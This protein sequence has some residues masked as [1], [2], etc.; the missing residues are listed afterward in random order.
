MFTIFMHGY[1]LHLVWSIPTLITIKQPPFR[2]LN[3][4]IYGNVKCRYTWNCT[5]LAIALPNMYLFFFKK[6]FV[7]FIFV[8]FRLD[9]FLTITIW[10]SHFFIMFSSYMLL[11]VFNTS[12]MESTFITLCTIFYDPFFL[13]KYLLSLCFQ[14]TKF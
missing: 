3:I 5:K 4:Y 1:I 6:C 12:C 2:M 13:S 7:Y 14:N 9:F 11:H 10:I 8:I